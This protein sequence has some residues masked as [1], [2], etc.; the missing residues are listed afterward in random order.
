MIVPC[1]VNSWL[2]CSGV[3]N[4][5]P[6]R[7]SSARMNRAI[8]PPIMNHVNEVAMYMTPRTFG[9]VV[10]RYCRNFAPRGARWTGYGRVTTGR[11]ATAVKVGLQRVGARTCH[12]QT[13]TE[14]SLVRHCV[15]H[16][17]RGSRL[18]ILPPGNHLEMGPNRLNTRYRRSLRITAASRGPPAP[19]LRLN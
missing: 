1:M 2:Y 6:G 14:L 19:P 12:G 13:A 4:C 8:R 15:E 11:G 5:I 18:Q 10:C 3:R 17:V 9:S 7:A 16:R